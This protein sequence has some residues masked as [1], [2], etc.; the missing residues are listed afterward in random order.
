MIIKFLRS[1]IPPRKWVIPVAFIC[2]G[3]LGV[4]SFIL[5]ISNATAYLSDDP[6]AC[7]NCHVMFPQYETWQ[8]SSHRDKAVCND[9]HVPHNSHLRKYLFKAQDG[10]RHSWMFTFR[11]EP[12]VIRMHKAGQAVVQENCIHCHEKVVDGTDLT[13][14]NYKQYLNGDAK[15][16]WQCHREVPHG[17]VKSLSATPYFQVPHL[18]DPLPSSMKP[19]RDFIENMIIPKEGEIQ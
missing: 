3:L 18:S 4:G 17:R 16:C 13:H 9:C 7:I 2:G 1:L 8:H 11:Q 19:L 6:K 12:Q 10:L 15:L 14:G 5:R